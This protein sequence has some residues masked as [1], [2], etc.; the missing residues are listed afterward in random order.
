M[1]SSS[2]DPDPISAPLQLCSGLRWSV[3]ESGI[4]LATFGA[5]SAMLLFRYGNNFLTPIVPLACLCVMIP[6]FKCVSTL[7]TGRFSG[8]PLP[9]LLYS[10]PC[11]HICYS[12]AHCLTVRNK[13]YQ[14]L[15]YRPRG[16]MI[17]RYACAMKHFR[18]LHLLHKQTTFLSFCFEL[19][20]GFQETHSY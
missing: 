3:T 10:S 17:Y 19:L 9:L 16:V 6:C 5:D 8:P 11:G 15:R 4:T 18:T 14:G 1:T 2:V 13:T 12:L 7:P 20:P